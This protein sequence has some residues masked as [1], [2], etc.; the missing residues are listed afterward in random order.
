MS[1]STDGAIFSNISATTAAF[2]LRGGKYGAASVAT[3]GG[4]SVKLQTLGPDGSTWLSLSTATD[5]AAA[6]YAVID[7]PAGQYRFTI[8][9]A[10]A[11]F[12]SV[13]RVPT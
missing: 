4:G 11:V 10:T 3:F 12:A 8:A 6:G 7:L 13:Y 5:F 1:T 2:Q 9:T